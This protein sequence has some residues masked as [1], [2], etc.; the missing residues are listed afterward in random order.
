[1]T[2]E[3]NST[4]LDEGQRLKSYQNWPK[5]AG[6]YNMNA[7]IKKWS[8]KMGLRLGYQSDKDLIVDKEMEEKIWNEEISLTTCRFSRARRA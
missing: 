7:E 6:I 1:M 4:D 3:V 2:S 5:K 8:L